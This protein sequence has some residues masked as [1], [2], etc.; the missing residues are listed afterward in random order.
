MT[1]V[2]V[3]HIRN[4]DFLTNKPENMGGL[5][6]A[7]SAD[8]PIKDLVDD[9]RVRVAFAFCSRQDNFR[10]S[11]GVSIATG[12][13]NSYGLEIPAKDFK[14]LINTPL[15]HMVMGDSEPGS[16]RLSV[17]PGLDQEQSKF[18]IRNLQAALGISGTLRI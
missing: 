4:L 5:T 17:L 7:Y 10:K 9:D 11:L 3:R 15:E 18:V 16:V 1:A 2:R 12:R 8:K 13:L 6:V 14:Q